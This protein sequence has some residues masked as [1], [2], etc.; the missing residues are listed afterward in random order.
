M[1]AKLDQGPP[2][3]KEMLPQVILDNY[4]KWKYHEIPQPGVLKH[5]GESGVLYSVRVAS[6]RLVSIDF[7]RDLCKIADD[8]CDGFLRFTT[9]NNVE[10]LVG[11]EAKLQPL[12]DTLAA[13]NYCVGGTGQSISNIIHTQG[14][15]H[16][17]TP[18]TDCFRRR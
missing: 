18:A 8:Y 6:P 15:V 14:W 1:A 13:Q 7:V 16:C 2:N 5:V 17:H 4:G 3:Y 9:R 10:F 11:D 12:L